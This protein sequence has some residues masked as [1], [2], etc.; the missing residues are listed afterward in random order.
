MNKNKKITVVV[1]SI[2]LLLAV[3]LGVI[4]WQKSSVQS[5]ARVTSPS[6]NPPVKKVDMASQPQWVQDL[7]VT[8]VKGIRQGE[9]GLDNVEINITGIPPATV[10]SLTYTIAYN[11]SNAN[12]QGSGGF[13]TDTPV[14]VNGA[15]SFSRT[16][17]FGTCST[18]SCVRHDGVSTMDIEFDFTTKNGDAPIWSKT[19]ELK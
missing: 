17:D 3:I 10:D 1:L 12:G 9:R 6:Q 11:Y 8:A 18:K 13:F 4:I 15:T 14:A 16:F 19:V 7:T 5:P 2:I